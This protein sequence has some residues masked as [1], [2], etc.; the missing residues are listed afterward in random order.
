MIVMV[1]DSPAL[2]LEELAD[3]VRVQFA[4]QLHPTLVPAASVSPLERDEVAA[5]L[6]YRQIVA[7]VDYHRTEFNGMSPIDAEY[8]GHREQ[9]GR[10]WKELNIRRLERLG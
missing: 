6:P 1:K 4:T 2:V 8:A 7:L 3:G 10:F 5:A 9:L